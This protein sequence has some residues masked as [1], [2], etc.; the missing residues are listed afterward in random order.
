VAIR[1]LL[2][3]F[4][5][6][7]LPACSALGEVGVA[8]RFTGAAPA[9]I[10][11]VQ[12][13]GYGLNA[14]DVAFGGADAVSPGTFRSIVPDASGAFASETHQVVYHAPPLKAPPP[15]Y[16]LAF[17]NEKT[18][19]YGMGMTRNGFDYRTIDSATHEPLDRASACWLIQFGEFIY[20][21]E[22]NERKVILHVAIAPNPAAANACAETP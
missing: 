17:S 7:L 3:A 4:T 9:E 13:Q 15:A 10:R 20:P 22:S 12:H 6:L 19:L 14:M 2:P 5:L 18:V 1:R 21:P 8:G 16:W 11:Y